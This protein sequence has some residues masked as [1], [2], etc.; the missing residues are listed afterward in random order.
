METNP[1][2]GQ[3]PT[4][5]DIQEQVIRCRA[6][7]A[8]AATTKAKLEALL[9][10]FADDAEAQM[11][12]LAAM[13]KSAKIDN[14]EVRIDE[15]VNARAEFVPRQ[16][17]AVK[18]WDALYDWILKEKR[19]DMLHKRVSSA[20]IV[21]LYQIAQD[22]YTDEMERKYPT[23]LE[24]AVAEYLPS[25]VEV[26]EWNELKLSESKPKKPRKAAR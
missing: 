6:A 19:F 22:H 12:V 1:L 4:V 5:A 18:D 24:F 16:A 2:S 8:K 10:P 26:T 11:K 23:V 3:A 14:M 7:T 13:M 15:T 25:G 21:E 17:P 9:K 20:P